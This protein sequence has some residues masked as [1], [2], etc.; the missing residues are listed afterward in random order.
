MRANEKQA[1][2]CR[3]NVMKAYCIATR[4]ML[5]RVLFC[6]DATVGVSCCPRPPQCVRSHLRCQPVSV[7]QVPPPHHALAQ[8]E[9]VAIDA[10]AAVALVVDQPRF[11]ARGVDPDTLDLQHPQVVAARRDG[12]VQ[13][14]QRRGIVQPGDFRHHAIEQVKDAIGFRHEGIEP[15][16]PV[17]AIAR[18][19]LVQQLGRTGAGFFGRQVG[20]RQVIA[21]LEVV[22]RFLEG[23]AALLIHQPRQRFGEVGMRI[24]R[25][26]LA[27]GFH[28]QRPA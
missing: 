17:H 3:G 14:G 4:L 5:D 8:V 26:R 20:Q 23:S 11:L 15:T 13:I 9:R 25:R 19:V 21:A 27:L 7:H 6:N 16:A 2:A 22:T 1:L 12:R 28:E 10:E 18:R 24:V